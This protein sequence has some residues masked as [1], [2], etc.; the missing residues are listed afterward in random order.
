MLLDLEEAY[1]SWTRKFEKVRLLLFVLISFF[2]LG[3]LQGDV[4]DPDVSYSSFSYDTSDIS[5]V[6]SNQ[7]EPDTRDLEVLQKI[8]SNMG[9]QPE[10][11]EL[12]KEN[13]M[14]MRSMSAVSN[15]S[16]NK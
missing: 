11:K 14:K 7:T 8:M 4:Q 15:N 10:L 5:A 6:R 3:R 12:F 1:S 9:S 16:C 2:L 13:S